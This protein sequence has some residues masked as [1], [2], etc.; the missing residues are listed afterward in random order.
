MPSNR[1]MASFYYG[2][3]TYPSVDPARIG[4]LSTVPSDAASDLNA[5]VA[6]A[7]ANGGNFP[8]K[9]SRGTPFKF[10]ILTPL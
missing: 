6:A 3:L 10:N 7:S 8:G 5:A 4:F 9:L 1:V 2:N